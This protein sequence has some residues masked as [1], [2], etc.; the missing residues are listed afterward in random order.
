MYAENVCEEYHRFFSLKTC[1]VRIFSAYGAGL[2]KQLFWDLFSKTK[3]DNPIS[4]FGTGKET[5]DFIYITDIVNALW[6]VIKKAPF[7]SDVYNL[8]NGEEVTIETAAS[9]FYKNLSN[10]IIF[11]FNGEER[12]GDPQNWEAD[13]TKIKQLGFKP[14]VSFTEGIRN[15]IE[16]LKDEKLV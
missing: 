3:T 1:S 5:R 10:K 8:A 12:K 4:L 9:L 6:L 15:Y 11:S 16:W 7:K 13:I 14:S 2:K